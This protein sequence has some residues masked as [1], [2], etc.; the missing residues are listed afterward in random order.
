MR[1]C[2][3]R[4][5]NSH[6]VWGQNARPPIATEADFRGAMKELSNWV[7]GENGM[8][9]RTAAYHSSAPT[10]RTMSHPQVT[11]GRGASSVGARGYGCQRLRRPRCRESR[12]RGE[13]VESLRVPVH[14]R[15]APRREGHGIA[16][17]SSRGFLD[18]KARRV[19]H[20]PHLTTRHT[21]Q[22]KGG[23]DPRDHLDG[24]PEREA[25]E[26]GSHHANRESSTY[27]FSVQVRIHTTMSMA[28]VM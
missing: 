8:S 10:G 20:V 25:T 22:P 4:S 17:Q 21:N 16:A 24:G 2:I 26:A 7:V 23:Q 14:G 9:S 28:N 18:V 3:G 12:R 19:E 15:A 13:T 5:K 6:H 11:S 1:T 27:T